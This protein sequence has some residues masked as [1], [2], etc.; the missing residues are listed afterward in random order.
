MGRRKELKG[1]CNDLLDSFVSRYN[2]IDGYWALGKFQALLQTTHEEQLQFQLTREKG[3]E[4]VFQQTL[5]YYR[6]SFERHLEVRNLSD[7]WVDR[8]VITV[9]SQSSSQLDC[10]LKIKADNGLE[11]EEKRVVTARPHKPERELQRR[12][13]DR[14]PSSQKGV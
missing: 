9:E 5:D 6:L 13:E 8:A 14:G 11:F 12:V 4:S 1:I 7:E 2:D 10:V 3:K